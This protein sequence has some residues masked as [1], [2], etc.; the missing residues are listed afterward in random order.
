VHREDTTPE[1]EK[2]MELARRIQYHTQFLQRAAQSS[3]QIEV[4]WDVTS[5]RTSLKFLADN[6]AAANGATAKVAARVFQRTSDNDARTL[7][8]DV[9]SR[10]NDKTARTEMLRLFR[11]QPPESEWRA[12]VAQRL[13]K[14]VTENERVK[15]S[16]AKVVLSEIGGAP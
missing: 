9:L 4:T 15:P 7:C 13:R 1:L 16:D 5:I 14:A 12:S 3:P 10:I 8:L 2:R 11:E 6:G